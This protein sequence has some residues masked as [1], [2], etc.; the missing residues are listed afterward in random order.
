MPSF[1]RE[2]ET[3][4]H[5][6]LS[7]AGQR[8]HEY[9]TLEHLLLAL[10]GDA[11]AS[12]VMVACGADLN[13][14]KEAVA[15]YLDT[16]LDALKVDGEADPSPTSGFQRGDAGIELVHRKGPQILPAESCQ[17]IVRTARRKIVRIHRIAALTGLRHESINRRSQG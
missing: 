11:D 7:A 9:A 5:N 16:E 6:A 14:L 3:T 8:H 17:G 1:A 4:L 15:L 13:E 10:C 2:L 12:K